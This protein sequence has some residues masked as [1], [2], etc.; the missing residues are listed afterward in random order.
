M[1][2]TR[3]ASNGPLHGT[4]N[5]GSSA[6]PPWLDLAQRDDEG[7][8]GLEYSAFEDI[9]FPPAGRQPRPSPPSSRTSPSGKSSDSAEAPQRAEEPSLLDR[10]DL[11]C[12]F[13]DVLCAVR[14][15]N[16]L[17]RSL[18]RLPPAAW[19]DSLAR[20]MR[21][22]LAG[23]KNQ[24]GQL[25]ERYGDTAVFGV[26]VARFREVDAFVRACGPFGPPRP[27]RKPGRADHRSLRRCHSSG[28]LRKNFQMTREVRQLMRQLSIAPAQAVAKPPHI[29]AEP[30]V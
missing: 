24:A 11:V 1:K 5:P 4:T 19:N 26:L 21:R 30:E 17:R 18:Y 9:V 8:H 14:R 3:E 7:P 13:E 2:E 15:V 10:F 16:S 29:K 22:R 28:L 27:P 12:K 25:L 20:S 6:C 23:L